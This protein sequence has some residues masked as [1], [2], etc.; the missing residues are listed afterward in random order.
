MVISAALIILWCL[1]LYLALFGLAALLQPGPALSFL[2][3]FAQTRRTNTIEGLARM[4]AG[5]AFIVLDRLRSWSPWGLVIGASLV[6]SAAALLLFP[7]V[8][9]R[10]APRLVGLVRGYMPLLG[11]A[12]LGLALL[13]CAALVRS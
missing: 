5:L 7:A 2:F 12:S 13:L 1:V 11:L 8:H 10:L 4:A 6:M 9:R 3:R